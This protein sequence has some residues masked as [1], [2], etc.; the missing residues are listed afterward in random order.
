METDKELRYAAAEFTE[1]VF[2]FVASI[3]PFCVEV[4]V[5][6]KEGYKQSVEL[7]KY[8]SLSNVKEDIRALANQAFQFVDK[9]YDLLKLGK[10]TENARIALQKNDLQP[11]KELMEVLLFQI[12]R[13]ESEYQI[14]MDRAREASKSCVDAA[15][16]CSVE[17]AKS[18]TKKNA[19]RVVGGSAAAGT[20]AAGVATGV[21]LSIAAGLVTAGVGTIVGLGATAAG[22]VAGG[23]AIAGTTAAATH[24]IATDFKEAQERYMKL[25]QYFDSMEKNA[26]KISNEVD[27]M[28]NGVEAFKSCIDTVEFAINKQLSTNTVIMVLGELEEKFTE[29]YETMSSHRDTLKEKCQNIY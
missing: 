15:G 25:A 12:S 22:A 7:A 17:A 9:V 11:L 8:P 4:H 26:Q 16:K 29:Y 28:R 1:S 18:K 23:A 24:L 2:V 21:G 3:T 27:M 13:I 10:N 20:L 19:S 14:F 6:I 5:L